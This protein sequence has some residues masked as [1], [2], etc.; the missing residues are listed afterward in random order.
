MHTEIHSNWKIDAVINKLQEFVLINTDL[1]FSCIPW[2]LLNEPTSVINSN[3]K[4][5]H[6]LSLTH[7]FDGKLHFLPGEAHLNE[8]SHDGCGRLL[9]GLHFLWFLQSCHNGRGGWW[10]S[11]E[12]RQDIDFWTLDTRWRRECDVFF[13][14]WTVSLWGE[15]LADGKTCSLKKI[16]QKSINP[17]RLKKTSKT[18]KMPHFTCTVFTDPCLF[19]LS[20]Q[21]PPLT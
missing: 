13:F 10:G 17:N 6:I 19:H 14:W 21:K 4:I 18:H 7:S 1:A 5:V 11:L 9:R 16:R 2:N 15:I 8:L 20:W 3:L 12:T